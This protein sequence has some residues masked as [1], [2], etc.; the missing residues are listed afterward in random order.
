MTLTSAL[1]SGWPLALSVTDPKMSA[2]LRGLVAA[3][4]GSEKNKS[5]IRA[6]AALFAQRRGR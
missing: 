3:D 1:G 6:S 5:S 4:I 2:L